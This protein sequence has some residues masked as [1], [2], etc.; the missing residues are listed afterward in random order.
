MTDKRKSVV[1]DEYILVPKASYSSSSQT[2]ESKVQ[3][4]S[5]EAK[6]QAMVK[7]VAMYM[8]E[9]HVEQPAIRTVNL[10]CFPGEADLISA[11]AIKR[12]N[13]RSQKMK[14][15]GVVKV[16]VF[17]QNYMTVGTSAALEANLQLCPSGASEWT[18]LA[19]L[20]G[21]CRCEKVTIE[22]GFARYWNKNDSLA[23]REMNWMAG[24]DAEYLAAGVAW[25][26]LADYQSA[27]LLNVSDSQLVHKLSFRPIAW[28]D[29][30][31]KLMTRGW[32]RTD[33]A[34]QANYY[35][36]SFCLDQSNVG[37][38]VANVYYRLRFDMEF[39]YRQ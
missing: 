2:T 10:E 26:T 23:N 18:N 25:G 14:K 29:S 6:Q 38:G 22:L 27:R 7:E 36:G 20:Y 31:T 3:V 8:L 39:R 34:T 12:A 17:V 16:P 33:A 5:K 19:A 37:S 11:K 15:G 4:D 30:S 13:F 28:I 21:E 24:W 1:S 35:V 32:Q 9:N